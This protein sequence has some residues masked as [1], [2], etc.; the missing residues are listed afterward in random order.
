MNT[1]KI[2]ANFQFVNNQVVE[3]SIENNSITTKEKTID[4]DCDMDYDVITC[5][6]VENGF[7]GVLHFIVGL[8][9]KIE[10]SNVFKI[11]LIM[12]GNFVGSKENL[13]LDDFNGM[14]EVNGTATLSQIARA[15]LTSVTSLSGMVPVNLPMVNI[16]SLKKQKENK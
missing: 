12:K 3:F 6:E 11:H 2:K 4:I 1:D 13:S 10:E 14:L 16:Y 7:V 8:N 5:T 9:A 15:Y